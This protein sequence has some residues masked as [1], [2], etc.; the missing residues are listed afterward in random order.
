MLKLKLVLEDGNNLNIQN[1]IAGKW[2]LKRHPRSLL[3]ES[4]TKLIQWDKNNKV[5]KGLKEKIVKKF[6]K[7]FELMEDQIKDIE[8]VLLK[9]ETR[10]VRDLHKSMKRQAPVADIFKNAKKEQIGKEGNT[11]TSLGGAVVS[12]GDLDVK[13]KGIKKMFKAYKKKSG[14]I[15][16]KATEEFLKNT[17]TGVKLEAKINTFLGKYVRGLDDVAKMIPQFI[18]ADRKLMKT[19]NSQLSESQG[20]LRELYPGL[21]Q[22]CSILQGNLDL[23]Y[24]YH[25][26]K[27][28]YRLRDLQWNQHEKLGSGSFADVYK[29]TL[30]KDHMADFPVAIKVCR[31]PISVSTISDILLED[32]TMRE[33]DHENLI[34]YYGTTLQQQNSSKSSAVKVIWIMILE[35]CDFTLKDKF[36]SADF[37]NPAKAKT[38]LKQTQS[39]KTMAYFAIQICSGLEY[40]HSK[41]LVHRDLKLENILVT[42]D[43]KVK[44]ADVGLTK[45][46]T[47]ISGTQ[48]GSPVYMAPEVHKGEDIYDSKVDIFSLG[49]ILWEMWYGMDAAEH[50]G[51]QIYKTLLDSLEGGLRPSL[52][53]QERPPD[54]WCTVMK[55]CWEYNKNNRPDAK[56]VKQFFSSEL[57]QLTK[58]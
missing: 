14:D 30:K 51:R 57:T 53:I 9:G 18:D 27:P 17:F 32:R 40:L 48:A 54:E 56:S 50:I 19:L 37:S 22:E 20:N 15:M 6:R 24:V 4:L 38:T 45:H 47:D 13:N 33:L 25:I 3:I 26:M 8:G 52:T 29:A 31:Q 28:D 58:L 5:V 36:L 12:A 39:M 10:V 21:I 44:L 7:D 23:F 43:D 11:T 46:V 41:G 55:A 42:S 16:E 1:P 2:W 49:I 34:K 35:F